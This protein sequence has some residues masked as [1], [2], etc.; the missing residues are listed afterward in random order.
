MNKMLKGVLWAGWLCMVLVG[1]QGVIQRLQ[2]GHVPA[3]YGSYIVWGLWVAAY[4][5]FMGLS[6]GSYLLSSL[7]YVFGMKR[8]ERIGR[9]SLFVAFVSLCLA[10]L[11]IW[12]DLGRMDR[13]LTV[14]TSPSFTSMMAWMIWLYSIYTVVI[15]CQLWFALRPELAQWAVEGGWRGRMAEILALHRGALTVRQEERARHWLKVLAAVG[16]PLA[17]SFNGGVGALFG[18]LSARTFWH[19]P[20]MP[21]LFLTGALVSGGALMAFLVAAFW[22]NHDS[23]YRYIVGFIGRVILGLLVFDIILEWAEFSIPMWYGVGHEYDLISRVLFGE[24]WWVFWVLHIGLGTIVPVLLLSLR[25]KHAWAVGT[26]GLLVVTTFMTV[27]LNIV[28]PGLIEPHLAGLLT[29]FQDHR[30]SFT[31]I[32]N[33]FEWSVSMFIV[34]LGIAAMY[35]GFRFLPL[36]DTKHPSP[37]MVGGSQS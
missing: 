26:A 24:F 1:A 10:L 32:P 23:D 36:T 17:V 20:L 9:L 12:F 6:A 18:T 33:W 4:I 22:P 37:T 25:G 14:L 15:I 5:F 19:T 8:L 28:V 21:I 35:L 29:A 3:A 34:S 13:A 27:R 16:F 30:L 2:E 11:S 31:Y 7:V